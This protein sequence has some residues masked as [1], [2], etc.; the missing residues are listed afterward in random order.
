VSRLEQLEGLELTAVSAIYSTRPV[1][2]P[3]DSPEFFNL[4][5]KGDYEYAPGELLRAMEDIERELGRE[6]KGENLPRTM[7]LDLLLFGD[8]EINTDNL[9]VPHPQL[10]KR[11]FVLIPLLQIDPEAV[12]PASGK[13]LADFVT[14]GGRAT[15]KLYKDHVA[16]EI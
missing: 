15:V 5:V 10:L 12:H 14:T 6:E 16:R 3:D 2:M 8:R 7:D 9:I 11:A 1:D 13:P 4:V